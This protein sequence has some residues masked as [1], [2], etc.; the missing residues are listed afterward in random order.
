MRVNDNRKVARGFTLVEMLAVLAIIALLVVAAL[1]S[2]TG[3]AKSSSLQAGTRGVMNTLG[4]ARQYAINQRTATRLIF[5][6]QATGAVPEMQ[7]RSYA[8]VLSNRATGAW[9]YLSKWE[10]LPTGV[11]FLGG[12]T[13]GGLDYLAAQLP[14][15]LVTMPTTNDPSRPVACLEFTARGTAARSKTLPQFITLGEGFMSATNTPRL[16]STNRTDIRVHP[17]TGRISM[18]QP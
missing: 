5:P 18:T 2:L 4:L 6:C 9:E 8:L 17:Y 14:L 3:L 13:P 12:N 15:V 1:P 16:T 10:E 11:V 7:Y